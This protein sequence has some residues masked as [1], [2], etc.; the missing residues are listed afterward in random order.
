LNG[1][2]RDDHGI[3]RLCREWLA[4]AWR[5]TSLGPDSTSEGGS[6]TA[7]VSALRRTMSL[8]LPLLAVNAL[9]ATT[10]RAN[11][12]AEIAAARSIADYREALRRA[13]RR[14]KVALVDI[15]AEWCAVCQVLDR[16]VFADPRILSLL[17]KLAFIRVDVTAMDPESRALLRHLDA[18]GPPTLF[19]AETRTG[20]ELPDTRSV[21][22]ISADDMVARLLP[23]ADAA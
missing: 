8:G 6:D 9:A 14:S 20:R 4:S 1:F 23:F 18:E 15:G 13:R 19:I 2:S 7:P 10:A 17:D 11:G 3:Y 12:T 22:R 5:T 16:T 21:G